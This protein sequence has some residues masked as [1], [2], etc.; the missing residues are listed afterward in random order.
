MFKSHFSYCKT[1]KKNECGHH[2]TH[3]QLLDDAT[4]SSWVAYTFF[5]C[6]TQ[7]TSSKSKCHVTQ[8]TKQL[9]KFRAE[10]LKTQII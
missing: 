9:D 6:F 1:I 7:L 2:K 3:L 4:Q 8:T 10:L 5:L